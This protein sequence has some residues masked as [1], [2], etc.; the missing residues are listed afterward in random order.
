MRALRLPIIAALVAIG[1][2]FALLALV[3]GTASL[4]LFAIAMRHAH[5]VEEHFTERDTLLGWINIPNAYK[6]NLFGTGRSLRI[7]GQRFRHTGELAAVPP[8]GKKRVVCSGDSFTLGYGVDDPKTWCALLAADEPSLETVNMGQAGYGIDQAYLWYVRDGLPLHPQVHVFAIITDDFRRMQTD[9]FGGFPKPRLALD[10]SGLHTVGVPVRKPGLGPFKVR[11]LNTMRT[12]RSFE[13][14]EHFSPSSR[15]S[16]ASA[17]SASASAATWDVTRAVLRDMD[18]RDSLAG[19]KFIVVYLPTIDD[20]KGKASDRW[21]QSI[22][23]AAKQDNYDYVDLVEELRRVSP[24]SVDGLFI[25]RG[26]L[27]FRG[28]AGHYTEAGNL[29]VE[30]L[31]RAR[32]PILAGR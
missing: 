5:F 25:P 4:G 2:L 30:K 3:E 18:V 17:T 16:S 27:A 20:F 12:L 19:A 13:L 32:V 31:L 22:Q 26:Q 21:R 15:A 23:D 10:R 29:W 9:R 6:P 28:A 8:A 7:N 14:L 11:L 24:D 1:L